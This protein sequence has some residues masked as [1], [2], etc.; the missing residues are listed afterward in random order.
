MGLPSVAKEEEG[1][2]KVT[3]E[4]SGDKSGPTT[5]HIHINQES[6]LTSFWKAVQHIRRP[7]PPK[8][9]GV[10]ETPLAPKDGPRARA[11]SDGEQKVLGG[12]QILL[13]AF[14]VALGLEILAGIHQVDIYAYVPFY[15][16]Q[17]GCAFWMGSVFIVAGIFSVVGAR[18]GGFW[19]PVATF[20][21]LASVVTGSVGFVITLNEIRFLQRDSWYITDTMC[22]NLE[23]R[24]QGW[25]EVTQSYIPKEDNSKCKAFVGSFVMFNVG[26]RIILL[27][28]AGV[29]IL[30]SLFGLG[31][32]LRLLCRRFWAKVDYYSALEEQETPPPC[33]NAEDP[34]RGGHA[35]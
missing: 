3:L 22:Q 13:G 33:G 26:V 29:A 15:I 18:R 7:S 35:A 31:Y 24:P 16:V 34:E 20:F 28:F 14:C 1:S 11:G 2:A 8:E 12:A 32:G 17:N 23:S 27:V 21:N 6:C 19:V 4:G 30:I 10:T 5:I 25:P 9:T